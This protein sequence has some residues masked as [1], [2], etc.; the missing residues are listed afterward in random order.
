MM[1]AL[2]GCVREVSASKHMERAKQLFQQKDYPRAAI[3]LNAVI[4]AQPKNAEAYY[5]LALVSL[6]MGQ[7]R[8]GVN[9]ALKA[10]QLD[11]N[12]A[13]AQAK[14]AELMTQYSN[15]PEV[16]KE[17]ETAGNYPVAIDHYRKVLAW[18]P[19]QV[20]AMQH[21]ALLLM[22]HAN[23]SDEALKLAQQAGEIAPADPQVADTLGWVLYRKGM[24]SVALKHLE[25][26]SAPTSRPRPKLHLALVYF[27][28][29]DRDKGNRILAAA[30]QQSPNMLKTLSASEAAAMS[31]R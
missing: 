5:Q 13:P 19:A 18:D 14:L 10:T 3:E 7:V 9:Y 27:K 24:Y 1:L 20:V 4:Q 11:P 29:G 26:A 8:A 25:G 16:L 23:E 31:S 21:L 17:A 28:L 2:S 15:D 6:A 30:L 22:D 12:Y